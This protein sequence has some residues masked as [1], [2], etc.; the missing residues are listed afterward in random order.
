MNLRGCATPAAYS[1]QA[2]N[3][4]CRSHSSKKCWESLFSIWPTIDHFYSNVLDYFVGLPDSLFPLTA[5]PEVEM[6]AGS[7]SRTG[8][9]HY[10]SWNALYPIPS[11]I[12]SSPTLV[13]KARVL[14]RADKSPLASN[15]KAA[16]FSAAVA[17]SRPIAPLLVTS[18]SKWVFTTLSRRTEDFSS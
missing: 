12:I 17:P 1:A 14:Y 4:G 11:S 2:T 7:W 13:S 10:A 3:S 9:L 5:I 8:D 16:L 18:A 6:W 15:F